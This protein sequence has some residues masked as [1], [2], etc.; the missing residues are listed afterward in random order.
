MAKMRIHELAKELDKQS[1]DI[2]ALLQEKAL[3]LSHLQKEPVL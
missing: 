2:I 3:I 1:K